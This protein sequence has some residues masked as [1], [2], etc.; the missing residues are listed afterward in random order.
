MSDPFSIVKRVQVTEKGTGMQEKGKYLFRVAVGAN[1]SQVKAAVEKLYGVT[2]AA[3]NTMN[4]MGKMKRRRGPKYGRKEDWK[5][6][7][8]TLKAGQKIEVV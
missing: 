8:V 5:R 4:Y 7:V 2:V 1:K 6:A 3:V